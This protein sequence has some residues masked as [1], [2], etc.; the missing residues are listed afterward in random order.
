MVRGNA[1]QQIAEQ[2]LIDNKYIKDANVIFNR[3]HISNIGNANGNLLRP[4]FQIPLPRD[5]VGILD[6]T[7]PGQAQKIYKYSPVGGE[8]EFPQLV[9]ITY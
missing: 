1:L 9:N 2:L 7:T 8:S 6:I 4:D 3:G 5:R